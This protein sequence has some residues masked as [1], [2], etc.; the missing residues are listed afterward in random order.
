MASNIVKDA[1]A[2]LQSEHPQKGI[3]LLGQAAS[4]N[5]PEAL[6]YLAQLCLAGAYVN[7]DLVLSRDLFRRA[8]AAGSKSAAA[9]YRAFVANGTGGPADWKKAVELVTLAA[10]VNPEAERERDLISAMHLSDEGDP[11]DSLPAERVSGSPDVTV[12]QSLFSEAECDFLIECAM[13]EFQPSEVIDPQTGQLVPNPIRTSDAAAFPLMS[14]RPAV[15]ALCRRL[16][17]ASGTNVRQGEPLQILRYRPGEEYRPHFDAIG[18]VDN[19][20]ILTFLVYLNDD[21]EGGETHFLK[22]DLKIKGRKGDGILFRNANASGR[23][24]P[25]SQHA[26]L[27]VTAGEKFLASRWIRARQ[28]QY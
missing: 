24:D 14:E 15:H 21:F 11:L 17:A 28:L 25:N 5:N 16:A 9:A 23:P 12:H 20:R 27:P 10:K 3:D 8:A 1:E 26:G 2:L 19:Q 7:R 6:E 13:P 4:G 22:P 18:G